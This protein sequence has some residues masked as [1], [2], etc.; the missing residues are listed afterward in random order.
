MVSEAIYHSFNFTNS[1]FIFLFLFFFS[2]FV[3]TQY[4]P[5]IL[6][7]LADPRD[8]AQKNRFDLDW[9]GVELIHCFTSE[10]IT[11]LLS[12]QSIDPLPIPTCQLEAPTMTLN[13][14]FITLNPSHPLIWLPCQRPINNFHHNPTPS[15]QRIL[16]I[17]MIHCQTLLV[18]QAITTTTKH[19]HDH[20]STWPNNWKCLYFLAFARGGL[21]SSSSQPNNNHTPKHKIVQYNYSIQKTTTTSLKMYS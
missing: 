17:T 19:P 16:F 18:H 1:Q 13:K 15:M 4:L 3:F 21:H 7:V 5:K 14:M 8:A 11:R 6:Q 2:L 12:Y 10:I 20:L 9:F